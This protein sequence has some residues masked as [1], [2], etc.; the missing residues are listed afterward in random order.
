MSTATIDA[1]I[2]EARDECSIQ[3][4]RFVEE[5]FKGVPMSTAYVNAGYRARGKSAESKASRLVRNGKVAWY[6]K[7][8]R[9]ADTGDAIMNR[10]E[11]LEFLSGVGREAR[12]AKQYSA[13]VGAIREMN[14]MTDEYRAESVNVASDVTLWEAVTGK[15]RKAEA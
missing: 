11:R 15:R 5:V 8:L 3:Q 6:L 13:G 1:A 2:L 10:R 4:Q 12:K 7:L 14:R 9:D